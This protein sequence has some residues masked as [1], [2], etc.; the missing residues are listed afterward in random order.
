M[1]A[2]IPPASLIVDI[3]THVYPPSYVDLLRS[4]RTIPY[5]HDP[6]PDVLPRLII[7][8]SDDDPSRPKELRGRPLEPDYSSLIAKREFMR[9]HGINVSVISLA[10]PWLDFIDDSSEALQW[11]RKINNDLEDSCANFNAPGDEPDICKLFAFAALPVKARPID[12]AGEIHRL[13][14][15]KHI[16]GVIIGTRGLGNGLDDPA[17]EPI[18]E[19]L[20]TNKL[21]AFIH[22]HYGLPDEVL[23]GSEVVAKSGHVL[24]LALGFPLETTIAVTRMFLA[25]VFD[26]FPCLEVLLAHSGGTLPFLA[27]RIQSCVEHEREFKQNGG[28]QQGPMR[29][30]WDVLS[31][32]IYLDAVIYAEP[33]LKAAMAASGSSERVLFGTDHP[34]FPP[35]KSG[36]GSWLSVTHNYD[37]IAAVAGADS[38]DAEAILGGNAVR[39]LNLEL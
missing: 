16:K 15:L 5:I 34:F 23:G 26:S 4:R 13:K 14:G 8:S 24:P 20:Q 21:I 10:N 27:G 38:K 1:D 25:R 39:L 19:A 11:A 36:A 29:D 3:H 2:S 28:P 37:A 17:L 33:G 22:P 9:D 35:L 30:L 12:I 6:S 31:S 32:N 7:L 18:W